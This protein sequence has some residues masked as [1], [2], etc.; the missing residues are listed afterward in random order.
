MVGYEHVQRVETVG[1]IIPGADGNTF[2]SDVVVPVGC[3]TIDAVGILNQVL[4]IIDAF[5]CHYFV[6]LGKEC[7]HNLALSRMIQ[8]VTISIL[9]V[10]YRILYIFSCL[11]QR[12][13]QSGNFQCFSK[14]T[15][16]AHAVQ[17]LSYQSRITGNDRVYDVNYTIGDY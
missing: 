10:R 11:G 6:R 17:L 2:F 15:K 1:I 7:V 4:K 12:V 8:F 16:L 9:R 14:D 3:T 13:G 5:L